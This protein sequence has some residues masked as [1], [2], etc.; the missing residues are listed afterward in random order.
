MDD[1]IN[2]RTDLKNKLSKYQKIIYDIETQLVDIEKE[3]ANVSDLEILEKITLNKQQREIVES[4]EKNMLVVACPGSGKTH[5]LISR[6]IYLVVKKKI[7]PENIV[8]I[9][10]TNKAGQE[11][12]ERISNLI[13]TSQPY[14]VGSLHGLSYRLLQKYN[15]IN[16]TILDES[17][18]KVLLKQSA[19]NIFKNLELETDEENLI[20]NQIVYIY[21]KIAT[22]Y[23]LNINSILNQ[24]NINIKY[25][26]PINLILKDYKKEKKE[27]LLLDF[28]DL[29]IM[30]CELLQKNKLD[31][32]LNKIEYIFFDEYQDVNPIQNYI[33]SYFNNKSNIMVV[34]DD[35]QA[36]YSFR[37]SN[38]SYIWEFENKFKTDKPVKKYLLE[39]NYRST[40]RIISFFQDV[41]SNNTKQFK[42]NVISHS[43]KKGLK[44]QI[45]SFQKE[46][47]QY[48]WVTESIVK[49]YQSGIPLSDM[50]V[51]AR[52]NRSLGG[53]EME[54]IKFK[55]PIV[56]SLGTA[57]LNKSHI[58][59]FIAFLIVLTNNKSLLHWKRIL[60]L[61]KNIGVQ[62]AN[63]II[64]YK[65]NIHI[66]INLIENN[67]KELIN[68]NDFYR[69]HLDNLNKLLDDIS[70]YSSLI[71]KIYL[72]H[73]YLDFIY[74]E[75]NDYARER[76]M[77]EIRMLT[78]Y[79]GETSIEDFITNIYLDQYDKCTLDDSLFLSTVHGAKGL[80]WK[81]V[82]IIDAT[83][84]D[85][86]LIRSSFY[87][88]E[89]D[90]SEEER[91][92]FYV[93]TSR[94]KKELTITYY[95]NVDGPDNHNIM[96]SPFIRELK[97]NS[98]LG[99]NITFHK[100][101]YT[102]IISKDV[103]NY[104][105]F[106]GYGLLAND[107]YNL[108][109]K[110]ININTHG[111]ETL[112]I[113]NN[114]KYRFII[115]NF[116]DHLIAKI[117]HNNFPDK[118]KNF[119]LNLIHLYPKF[120]K[121]LYHKYKDKLTDWRDIL[122]DI[123]YISTYNFSNFNVIE[124]YKNYLLNSKCNNFYLNLEKSIIKFIQKL[125]P[126]NINCHLNISYSNYRGECD[127]LIDDTLIELKVSQ[128]EACTFPNLCQVLLYGFLLKKKDIN[129]NSVNI[130]NI[131][132]GNLDTFKTDNFN[133]TK[134]K[135]IVYS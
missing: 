8:L 43:E 70:N 82:Y 10:F 104:L 16:Y 79:F 89:L 5:T 78:S 98:Y 50:V 101:G 81:Y 48:K 31:D 88:N 37:G 109:H 9:T 118:V 130:Y 114:L 99:H 94:A 124:E 11:M 112:P 127:L 72:V 29:M 102:G 87:K 129:I 73:Q 45:M 61:H 41:I 75:N 22:S 49:K 92:L 24:L 21:E 53:I 27:Q 76:K 132:N 12:K 90:N 56:K 86:P 135:K 58:K 20:K 122:E 69:K 128:L 33:L 83:S 68:T 39:T 100:Y 121:N 57:L 40:K 38:V 60:A 123:Y 111:K 47:E 13:P 14:Y 34:G 93:A 4:E 105:N 133:F 23:P 84:K 7:N 71:Q 74:K 106:K 25:K 51:L 110:R 120:P 97:I 26:K 103:Q 67:I 6:Y 91:R 117:I 115:G 3:M 85:L 95:E 19:N 113:P 44:P 134:L 28:N 32:F 17:D 42:K 15:K 46:H 107:I 64:E 1:L 54:L 52:T 55:L 35:S 2:K 108:E 30:I 96:I 77:D 116:M 62:K 59:D 131:F 66:N 119:D 80:E 18:S 36:I 125:K 63:Y 65:N 126:K